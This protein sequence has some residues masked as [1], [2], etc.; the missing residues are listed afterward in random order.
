MTTHVT[1]DL[2]KIFLKIEVEIVDFEKF[3]LSFISIYITVEQ[4]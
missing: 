3:L 2:E 4:F 1:N